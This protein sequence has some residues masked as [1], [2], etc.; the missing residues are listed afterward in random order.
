M[1]M[2]FDTIPVGYR[3]GTQAQPLLAQK[4]KENWEKPLAEWRS[5]LGIKLSS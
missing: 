4:W 2:L 5:Q 3:M 1:D